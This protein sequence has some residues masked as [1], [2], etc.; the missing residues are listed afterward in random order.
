MRAKDGS[1]LY[2]K[3]LAAEREVY[4]DFAIPEMDR[5]RPF[6]MMW[7]KRNRSFPRV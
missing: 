5:K 2:G 4:A 1:V 6:I 3:R 7:L